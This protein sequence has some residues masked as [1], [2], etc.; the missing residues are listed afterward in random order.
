MLKMMKEM[1]EP[2]IQA[3][4]KTQQEVQEEK[5]LDEQ[6]S[7]KVH[8]DLRQFESSF[9]PEAVK[10]VERIEHENQILLNHANFAFFGIKA[11]IM[12]STTFDEVWNHNFPRSQ[13][14]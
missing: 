10:I 3:V 7:A 14:K 12:K 11:V 4:N 1:Q 2:K 9:N 5:A 13:E 8:R 6:K